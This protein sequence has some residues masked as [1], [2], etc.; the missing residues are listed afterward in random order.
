LPQVPTDM[1]QKEGRARLLITG[2]GGQVGQELVARGGKAGFD[3][4]ALARGD[5][6][7]VDGN[8]VARAIATSAPDAVINAA[9]YTAVDRAESEPEIAHAI[10]AAGAGHIARACAEVGIPVLHISTDYVFDGRG[11]RPY[12]ED[13]P[14]APQSVYGASKAAGEE[15]TRKATAQHVI[16]RTSWVFGA[17]GNNF[18]KTML[19]LASERDALSVVNDQ[20]GCPSAAGDIADVLLTLAGRALHN[21]DSFPWGTYH[22]CNHGVTSWH[23][24]ASAILREAARRG[25]HSIPVRGIPTT[26]YPTPARRPAWSVLDCSKLEQTFGITPRP[27]E[28]ALGEVLDVLVG[29]AD[30]THA[31]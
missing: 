2:A 9:A 8:A 26:D 4:L 18:V 29:P 28:K 10:N 7:I 24:F 13:D 15:A 22:F 17:Q 11:T 19:R 25:A 14:I 6:D 16:L 27:W 3:V 5:L 21:R 23:G 20:Q 12:R 31:Q 1:T 30:S